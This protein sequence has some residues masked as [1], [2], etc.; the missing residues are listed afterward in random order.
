MAGAKN[1]NHLLDVTPFITLADSQLILELIFL[2]LRG[3]CFLTVLLENSNFVCVKTTVPKLLV[4][5]P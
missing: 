5:R 4:S 3:G 2:H 1:A